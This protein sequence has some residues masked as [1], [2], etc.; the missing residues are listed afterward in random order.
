MIECKL[1]E[2]VDADEDDF[3]DMILKA[4]LKC[5]FQNSK[6]NQSK[7]ECIKISQFCLLIGL[8]LLSSMIIMLF[9]S[10]PLFN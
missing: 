5:N 7:A 9:I 3:K 1:E 6:N 10:P 2:Y 4:Y 8:G